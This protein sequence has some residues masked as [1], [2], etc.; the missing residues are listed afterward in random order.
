M[1]IYFQVSIICMVETIACNLNGQ[2]T[3]YSIDSLQ[4]NTYEN[5]TIPGGL[6]P[7]S[8]IGW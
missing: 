2:T 4:N 8:N 7:H 1:A 5:K 6:V 3:P